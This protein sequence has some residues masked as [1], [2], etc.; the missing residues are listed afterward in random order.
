MEMLTAKNRGRKRKVSSI[1]LCDTLALEVGN[2]LPDTDCRQRKDPAQAVIASF[3]CYS[4]SATPWQRLISHH[5]AK[6]V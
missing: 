4:Y 2:G 5:H 3:T 6:R 1:V